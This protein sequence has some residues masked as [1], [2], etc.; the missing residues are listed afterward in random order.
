MIVVYAAS[1]QSV[2]REK[3]QYVKGIA[4]G[5]ASDASVQ[6]SAAE[7]AAQFEHVRR[8]F[9]SFARVCVA[10]LVACLALATPRA[11]RRVPEA[12]RE[13]F[14]YLVCLAQVSAR[15]FFTHHRHAL[16]AVMSSLH[17]ATGAPSDGAWST[18]SLFRPN[19]WTRI[20]HGPV[21]VPC[22]MTLF[23]Y[24]CATHPSPREHALF[25]ALA[26]FA[27][28][29]DESAM[30]GDETY[31][32]LACA[33]AVA[34]KWRAW[35]AVAAFVVVV[36]AADWRHA[37]QIFPRALRRRRRGAVPGAQASGGPEAR[38]PGDRLEGGTAG[39]DL[40]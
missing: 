38:R 32:P 17:R 37:R 2:I 34:R 12:I 3:I 27:L 26:A 8:I 28:S 6:A 14:L 24:L 16:N 18:E 7:A 19:I 25:H 29:Q 31:V 40:L 1:R 9:A 10:S 30:R 33:P 4:R 5:F 36:C 13:R 11:K 22:I 15:F 20:A 39:R 35:R 23:Y 21:V